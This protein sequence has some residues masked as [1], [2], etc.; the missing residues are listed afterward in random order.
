MT[1]IIKTLFVF[2]LPLLSIAQQDSLWNHFPSFFDHPFRSEKAGS[3][4][5]VEGQYTQDA[6]GANNALLWR[7][8]TKQ[9]LDQDLIAQNADKA[10]LKNLMGF[11]GRFSVAYYNLNQGFLKRDSLHYF[12][13]YGFVDH[14]GASYSD[15]FFRLVGQG[16]KAF[17]G[18][19]ANGNG[20]V[21]NRT[22]FDYID[23]GVMKFFS[24]HSNLAVSLGL[25]RGIRFSDVDGSRFSVYTAEYGT[26]TYWDLDIT[27]KLTPGKEQSMMD[28]NGMG[29]Q[30]NFDYKGLLGPDGA[31]AIG[32]RNL[33]FISWKGKQYTKKDTFTYN[34]WYAPDYASFY[35]SDGGNSFDSMA[36]QFRPDSSSFRSAE[37]LPAYIYAEYTMKLFGK[38]SLSF[39]F[40]KVIN[41]PMVPRVSVAYTY[42]CGDW[43]GVTRVSTG[44]YTR[45]NLS[46][47]VALRKGNHFFR[48]M[49]YGIQAW[50]FPKKAAG[51]GGGFGY[52]WMF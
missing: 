39:R 20:F 29:L 14:A 36:N 21:L 13:R 40:D 42:F 41:T 5:V 48:A 33:G 9:R 12:V 7:M 35:D 22:R 32:A 4:L 52:S 3:F 1:R 38:Q 18:D 47:E 49:F 8:S 10:K 31:Y 23:F 25:T 46:Q 11:D 45:F 17:E 51:L 30:L 24:N 50:A 2:C 34:G 27:A 28:V 16:N 19:T 26:S 15:E 37:L 6:S 44:G 43:Y